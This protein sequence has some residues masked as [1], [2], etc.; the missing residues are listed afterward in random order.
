VLRL[1]RSAAGGRERIDGLLRFEVP[2]GDVAAILHVPLW[3]PLA[4]DPVV[5][6]ELEELDGRVRV[7][8]A[9][10]HGFRIEVRIPEPVDEPLEG[11]VR[12]TAECREASAAA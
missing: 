6:C 5:T 11:V 3:P 4:G 10:A 1:S 8:L 9:K 7:P 2:A 12:F